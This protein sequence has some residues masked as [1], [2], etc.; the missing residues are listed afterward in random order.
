MGTSSESPMDG[1]VSEGVRY[2]ALINKLLTGHKYTG[3]LGDLGVLSFFC[4]ASESDMVTVA[5]R[6]LS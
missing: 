3:Y 6:S 1:D 5:F 2:F 4:E